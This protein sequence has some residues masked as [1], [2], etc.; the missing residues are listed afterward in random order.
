MSLS[1]ESMK[2]LDMLFKHTRNIDPAHISQR[3]SAAFKLNGKVVNEK[4]EENRFCAFLHVAII[5]DLFNDESH[6]LAKDQIRP[7]GIGALEKMGITSEEAEPLRKVIPAT[8]YVSGACWYAEQLGFDN[9][10]PLATGN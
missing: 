1:M 9:W 3:S 6:I 10:K 2:N 8:W 7:D 4:Y 5:A